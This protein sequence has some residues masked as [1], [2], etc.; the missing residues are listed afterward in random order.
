[1]RKFSFNKDWKCYKANCEGEGYSVTLPHDAMLLDSRSENSLGGVNTGWYDANDY[2]YDKVFSLNSEYEGQ[3]IVLEFEGIYHNAT[4]YV[5]NEKVAYHEYGYTGFY[6][7]VTEHVHFGENKVRVQVTNSDQPN[8]R[9]YTGTGIYR[10]VW[11][12]YIPSEYIQLDS[13]RITTLDEKKKVINIQAKTSSHGKIRVEILDKEKVIV[14]ENRECDGFLNIDVSLPNA[15]LWNPKSPQLYTCKLT[16]GDDVQKEV[17]GIRRVTCTSK[18]GFCLNG[19]RVI[20]NGAC[21][22]HDN[23]LLGAAA[24]DFAEYRKVKLLKENGYNAIRCS[25]NP[26]SKAL[27]KACDEL[28][29]LVMDEYA[30]MWYI[31]KTRF[32]YADHVEK[33]YKEDLKSII[34]KNYNHPSVIMYSIG[35]EVS[36]TAQEKGIEL[37]SKMTEFVHQLDNTRPVT[38]GINIFFNF[39]SS[40]GLGVYSDK[41]AE[42]S[43]RKKAVGSEFF[44]KLAGIMGAE[45][46]KYGATLYP[47]D[48]KTRGAFSKLDVAGYNY[49]IKRYQKDLKKY[50]ER[51]ILGT[52]TFCADIV[53]FIELAEKEPRLIGDFVWTGMD[54]LGETGLGAQEYSDYAKRFDHGCGWLTAGAGRIDITGKPLA[55]M[56]YTKVALGLDKIGIGVVPVNHTKDKHSPSAWAMT[57][58]RE[59]WSWNGCGGMDARI[60]VYTK[61]DHV[62]LYLNGICV[63]RKKVKHHNR[64]IF[65]TKYYDGELTAQAYDKSGSL[66]AEE[67]L[68]TASDKTYL[69]IEPELQTVKREKELCYVRMKYTDGEGIVKP[70]ERGEIKVSVK[71]GKLL[72]LGSGCPYYPQGYLNNVADTYYGEALAIILPGE[73]EN[74]EV[75]AESKFGTSSCIIKVED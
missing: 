57:N 44:N 30:D 42:K 20:L 17:F 39:L 68:K 36:E 10:S 24:Y 33:N 54:Y 12:Y 8:S 32:D 27:L 45:F 37:C 73:E 52:E 22:H 1:M 49:G 23:G 75:Y 35:N 47:C 53:S 61:A 60:E 7:D 40:I 46:M 28:G 63:G 62:K 71:G 72:G 21:I 25:H 51:I 3:K 48:V 19:E 59:S 9:W 43:T 74:V 55:E 65:K 70:L 26:C 2:I 34:A 64:V 4:V 16:F 58:A 67:T 41:K 6:V 69:L 56:K 5:N 18:E 66:L 11:L 29:M 31:H 38:C 13:I 50:P 14:E 15:A